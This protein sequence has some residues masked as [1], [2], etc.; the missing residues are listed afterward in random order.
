M[1]V[2]P[3]RDHWPA[4]NTMLWAGGGIAT[5]QVVGSTDRRGEYVSQR[6]VGPQ[7]FL[8]TIY[9][10]LGI[11]YERVTINDFTGRPHFLVQNGRPIP[12]LLGGG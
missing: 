8:A 1:T 3:G 5:G 9:R 6:R 10:H 7:D 11:D 12:E 2:Q 4:A